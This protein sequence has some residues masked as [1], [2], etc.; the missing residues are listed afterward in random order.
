MLE[1]FLYGSLEL[2]RKRIWPF[3]PVGEIESFIYASNAQIAE[4]FVFE[5]FECLQI[6]FLDWL[7]PAERI[8]LPTFGLQDRCTTAVLRRIVSEYFWQVRIGK[9]FATEFSRNE[10]V[11]MDELL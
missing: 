11:L 7:V 9:V 5:F 3:I 10:F 8:E 6:E 2:H 1:K 4:K